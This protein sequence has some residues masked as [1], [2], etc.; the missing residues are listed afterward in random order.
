[1]T[2]VNDLH[3]REVRAIR[4]AARA[5]SFL[6]AAPWMLIMLDI[7]F[8]EMVLGCITLAWETGLLVLLTVI[9]VSSTVFAW[10][11]EGAGG[12]V[13]T[14]WGLAFTIIAYTTSRP[15]VNDGSAVYDCRGFVSGKLVV[16]PKGHSANAGE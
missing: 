15:Y 2:T 7:L 1:M 9:S 8:C 3:W 6:A 10:R 13:M 4:W 12:L 14:L 16:V 5:I 11:R